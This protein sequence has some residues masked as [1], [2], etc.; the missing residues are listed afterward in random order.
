MPNEIT[1]VLAHGQ[2]A[3]R[4]LREALSRAPPPR[5]RER[6]QALWLRRQGGSAAAVAR[7]FARAPHTIGAWL[8]AFRQHGPAA[9]VC[10]HPGGSP[11]P[12]TWPA[13]PR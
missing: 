7:A 5:P 1:A 4:R 3:P 11:P 6:W 13:K 2:S 12:V 10:E 8:D 9:L